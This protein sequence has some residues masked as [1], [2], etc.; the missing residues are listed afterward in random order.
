MKVFALLVPS[1]LVTA[2][3]TAVV[4]DDKDGKKN[5]FA[6]YIEKFGPPGPEHKLLEPL[7]GTWHA[8]V[9]MW[10]EPG[11]SPQTSE[12]TLVRKSVLDGRF[13]AEKY[14]GK[15]LD[16]PFQGMGTI[17][18]DRAKKKFV[19]TWMDSISTAVQ[20]SRGTYD[21]ATRT[22][23]FKNEDECPITGKP[24]KMRDT[25][26]IVNP[27]EQ[28]MEMFRQLG[29]EKEMKMMEITL[30]RKKSESR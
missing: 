19:T 14:D 3:A 12:G 24:V 16:K 2:C 30:T 13:V 5:L 21:E 20:T 29:D 8:N 1:L 18:Y 4:A 25:L 22:W 9:K 28:Q 23:T 27:D 26:R 15:M 17:G 6:E 7:V 10:M 11:Q